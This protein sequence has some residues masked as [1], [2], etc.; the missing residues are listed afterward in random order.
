MFELDV[1]TE[2]EHVAPELLLHVAK[3]ECRTIGRDTGEKACSFVHRA[4]GEIFEN[5]AVTL[6]RSSGMPD[7]QRSK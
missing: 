6:H 5:G 1:D 7:R 3:E 2:N 4:L